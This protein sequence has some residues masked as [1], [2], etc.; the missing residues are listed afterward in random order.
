M[1]LRL[2]TCLQ[3]WK[4]HDDFADPQLRCTLSESM[5]ELCSSVDEQATDAV[6]DRLRRAERAPSESVALRNTLRVR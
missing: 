3:A 6:E 1:I 5:D 4:A 2:A